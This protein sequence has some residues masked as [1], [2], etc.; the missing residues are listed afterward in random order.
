VHAPVKLFSGISVKRQG[1]LNGRGR[2]S[3]VDLLVLTSS[4][5]LIFVLKN[6]FA[7]VIKPATLMRWSRVL[8]LPLL[9]VFPER[10]IKSFSGGIKNVSGNF[11]TALANVLRVDGN[12]TP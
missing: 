5:Q 11:I 9:L 3:T 6:L 1:T 4:D 12:Q 2:L 10:G 7:F 8:S